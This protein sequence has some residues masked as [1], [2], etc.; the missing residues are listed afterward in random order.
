MHLSEYSQSLQERNNVLR[1][2]IKLHKELLSAFLEKPPAGAKQIAKKLED[3]KHGLEAINKNIDSDNLNLLLQLSRYRK[4]LEVE[5]EKCSEEV[6]TLENRHF[7]LTNQLEKQNNLMADYEAKLD[8]LKRKPVHGKAME[9]YVF[10]PTQQMLIL[11]QE[12]QACRNGFKILSKDLNVRLNKNEKLEQYSKQL[13]KQ[14][15]SLI[16]IIKGLCENSDKKTTNCKLLYFIGS[17]RKAGCRY[18][19]NKEH[20]GGAGKLGSVGGSKAQ[21]HRRGA[22]SFRNP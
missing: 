2:A 17:G 18:R 7:V 10:D 4:E 9:K 1:T 11:Q 19:I 15:T 13:Q 12:L 21:R 3:T 16:G 6:D 22:T 14:N 20:I 8:E 5:E